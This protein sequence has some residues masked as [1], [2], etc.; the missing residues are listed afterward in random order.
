M[1]LKASSNDELA[2]R[3]ARLKQMR[4]SALL[5]LSYVFLFELPFISAILMRCVFCCN[6]NQKVLTNKVFNGFME[7]LNRKNVEYYR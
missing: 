2:P 5:S 4:K 7:Y 3:H 6:S 1:K